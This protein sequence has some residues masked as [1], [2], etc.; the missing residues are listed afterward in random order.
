M[1]VGSALCGGFF[2]ASSGESWEGVRRVLH[3]ILLLVIFRFHSRGALHTSIPVVAAI[4]CCLGFSAPEGELVEQMASDPCARAVRSGIPGGPPR[5]ETL[6][7]GRDRRHFRRPRATLA[8][9]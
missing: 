5:P 3:L 9:S 7:K 4:R 1:S 2:L 6:L 8:S